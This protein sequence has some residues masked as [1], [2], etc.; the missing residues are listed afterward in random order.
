MTFTRRTFL[1]ATAGV[2]AAAGGVATALVL[3]P[4]P[5]P[6]ELG[7]VDRL[8][9]HMA[10]IH[11]HKALFSERLPREERERVLEHIHEHIKQ[12]TTVQLRSFP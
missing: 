4:S 12:L 2:A 1:K 11:A 3:I 8:D 5:P 10:H 9:D 7:Q 6:I